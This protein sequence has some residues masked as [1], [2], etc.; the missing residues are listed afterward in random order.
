MIP[1]LLEPGDVGTVA[2]KVL[3]A[4]RQPFVLEG[5]EVR[6]SASLGVSLFPADGGD[7]DTLVRRADEALYRAKLEG[8]NRVARSA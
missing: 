5:R 1:G 7:P 8:R 6:I 3:A 4:V 2:E